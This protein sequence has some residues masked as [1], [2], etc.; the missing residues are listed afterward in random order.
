MRVVDDRCCGLD[1]HKKSVVACVMTPESQDTRTFGTTTRQLL[2]LSDWLRE[3]RVTHVAMESTGVYWK[4]IVNLME[5]E[6]S[7]WVVNARHIRTVP[8]RKTDVKDAEWIADLLRHGL[9]RPSFI[10][11]RPQRELR[12]LARYRRSLVQKR[13]REANRIQKVLEGPTSSWDRCPR[14]FRIPPHRVP[15]V[16]SEKPADAPR[17][18]QLFHLL[19]VGVEPLHSGVAEYDAVFAADADHLLRLLNA[20]GH[21]LFA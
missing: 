8:G 11:E 7:V 6:F 18:D 2:E 21:W 9:L 12:E 17:V 19:V 5:D 3:R 10:P 14:H 4:P 20:G 13:S 15:R 16:N 1:V